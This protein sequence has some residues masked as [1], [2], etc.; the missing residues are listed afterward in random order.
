ME[1]GK[2]TLFIAMSN[3]NGPFNLYDIPSRSYISEWF[4]DAK[5]YGE[6]VR[7]VVNGSEYYYETTS[8]TLTNIS[9][10][11]QKRLESLTPEN[12]NSEQD[13]YTF[14]PN[15]MWRIRMPYL[16]ETRSNVIINNN[17]KYEYLFDEWYQRIPRP[18]GNAMCL[19]KGRGGSGRNYGDI[20]D[21]SKNQIAFEG[22]EFVDIDHDDNLIFIKVND[23][24][25]LDDNKY[26]VVTPQCE[27]LFDE[28]IYGLAFEGPYIKVTKRFGDKMK[29]N[30]F[31]PISRNFVSDQY[32]DYIKWLEKI[33]TAYLV[34]IDNPNDVVG[35]AG[36]HYS[37]NLFRNGKLLFEQ[38]YSM[39]I[40]EPIIN[41]YV[42][43]VSA[44]NSKNITINYGNINTGELISDKPLLFKDNVSKIEKNGKFNFVDGELN[45]LLPNWADK[46]SEFDS[47]GYVNVMYGNET[48]TFKAENGK[49]V[50]L[51]NKLNISIPEDFTW[52]DHNS[53]QLVDHK[54]E[55]TTIGWRQG[56]SEHT[57]T[58][59][60]KVVVTT[61]DGR[62]A[63]RIYTQRGDESCKWDM[64]ENYENACKELGIKPANMD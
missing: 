52:S 41:D 60:Q 34:G 62:S 64:Y 48:Y 27:L 31:D 55:Y 23:D 37:Y 8:K 36:N 56:Q 49:L 29:Y 33:P 39:I 46:V 20:Y 50:Q 58:Y 5:I 9:D 21:I 3:D 17:G 26:N 47:N 6:N 35:Y 32:F 25:S 40:Y 18:V 44:P 28:P 24:F 13:I 54:L 30:L 43:L 45:Y 14:I 63:S 10:G 11:R 16:D 15:K 42:G 19:I 38:W 59:R 1:L 51:D 2:D 57:T 4:T 22:V 12:I 61:S 7:F 53:I